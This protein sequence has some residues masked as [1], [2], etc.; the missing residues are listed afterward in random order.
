MSD[1][2]TGEGGQCPLPKCEQIVGEGHWLASPKSAATYHTD[3]EGIARQWEHIDGLEVT[4]S[5]EPYP[6]GKLGH[7]RSQD[8]EPEQ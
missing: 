8:A 1:S 2:E 5:T 6:E 7:G 4:P 3:S